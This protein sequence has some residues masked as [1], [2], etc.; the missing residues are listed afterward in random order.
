[1]PGSAARLDVHQ[2]GHV[3]A[4]RGAAAVRGYGRR[5]DGRRGA[6]RLRPRHRLSLP[7]DRLSRPLARPERER[8]VRHRQPGQRHLPLVVRP[9]APPRAR[10]RPPRNVRP[11][12]CRRRADH[13]Q[14]LAAPQ[15]RRSAICAS[16]RP[17]SSSR[18]SRPTGPARL[19]LTGALRNVRPHRAT[20]ISTPAT[21]PRCSS[22]ASPPTSATGASSPASSSARASAPTRRSSARPWGRKGCSASGSATTSSPGTT[23]WR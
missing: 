15:R 4:A 22:P 16:A 21:P 13:G 9:H 14:L 1:M 18:A 20:A 11:D 7:P 6:L 23:S 12:R 10:L 5:R 8:P 19:G 3:L 2:L 17:T